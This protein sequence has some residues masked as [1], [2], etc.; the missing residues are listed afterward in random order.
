MRQAAPR[1]AEGAQWPKHRRRGPSPQ[2]TFGARAL[3]DGE[4]GGSQALARLVESWAAGW[5]EHR[6]ALTLN[7]LST[8]RGNLL[9]LRSRAPL[10]TVPILRPLQAR[11]NLQAR[12]ERLPSH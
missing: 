1:K 8:P 5:I 3:K 6:L 12:Q 10:V 7:V 11:P 9:D 4:N 2:E